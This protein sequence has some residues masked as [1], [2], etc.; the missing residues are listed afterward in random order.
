MGTLM[1][2]QPAAE[3]SKGK[4]LVIDD[5]RDIADL[6][7]AI[8]TDEGFAVSLL[9]RQDSD[10]IR[11][12]VGQ[13]EPDC[14][15]LD[16]ESPKGYGQSWGEASWLG[17]RS[18]TVPVIMFSGSTADVHEA[19]E[20]ASPRSQEAGFTATLP[21]P[22]NIDT[23]VDVVERAIGL[24][25]PFNESQG[26]ERE[27]TARLVTRLQDAGATEV[28]VSTRREWG[29]FRTEDGT[30]VQLYWWQRDGA[31][32]VVRH[33]ET[34]GVLET[35]GRFYDLDAAITMAMTVRR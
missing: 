30:L 2:E 7:Y 23:L 16:G 32:Y 27:R 6:V 15:L 9:H 31:Y 33:A 34:G 12:A 8:L 28:H 10:S 21:K 19:Q 20:S 35:L 1:T 29:N 26:G 17:A 25:V 13:V 3:R 11:K 4:V 24:A 5:D 14:V 22:F 18:R